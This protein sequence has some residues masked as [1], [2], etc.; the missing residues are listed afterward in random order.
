MPR[1][2]YRDTVVWHKVMQEK[3]YNARGGN[4]ALTEMFLVQ[5]DRAQFLPG[6][7]HL[8]VPPLAS[9]FDHSTATITT[10]GRAGGLLHGVDDGPSPRHRNSQPRKPFPEPPYRDTLADLEARSY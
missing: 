5:V 6:V 10:P 1:K 4:A 2:P 7:P 8:I 9:D 3:I